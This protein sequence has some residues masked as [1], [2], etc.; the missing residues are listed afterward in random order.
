MNNQQHR[1]STSALSNAE[2][3]IIKD[4]IREKETKL[5]NLEDLLHETSKEIGELK[6]SIVELEASI[7]WEAKAEKAISQVE[8]EIEKIGEHC[9]ASR[10]MSYDKDKMRIQLKA[11]KKRSM[12]KSG[13]I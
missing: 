13:P 7:S 2:E 8:T 1:R 4:S 3:N 6:A 10:L 5:K 9:L 12:T 11:L